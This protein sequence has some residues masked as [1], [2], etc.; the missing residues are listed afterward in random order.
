[1]VFRRGNRKLGLVPIVSNKEV[2]DAAFLIVA[3]GV[4]T[5][6]SLTLAV[7]DYTG[8]VGTCPVNCQIKG[9]YL[10]TS[11]NSTGTVIG[12]LDWY[13]VKAPGHGVAITGYP[14]PGATGGSKYRSLIFHERKGIFPGAPTTAGG[15]KS[16][17]IEFISIPKKFRKMNEDDRWY[18]RI[19]ASENY[20]FCI[21]CIYKWYV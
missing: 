15:Q 10:E 18:I 7:N 1:M 19:G 3:A 11:Y 13:L 12:R 6:V 14:T 2:V 4:T 21:K 5:D 8:T 16:S 9:F 17:S 20:S